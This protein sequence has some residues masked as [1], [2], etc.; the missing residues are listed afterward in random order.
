MLVHA[1]GGS[2]AWT[3]GDVDEDRASSMQLRHRPTEWARGLDGA[4]TKPT[5]NGLQIAI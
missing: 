4:A 2:A 5:G 3:D 1:V